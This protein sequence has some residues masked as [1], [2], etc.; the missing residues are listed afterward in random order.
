M[1]CS[2]HIVKCGGTLRHAL[3]PVNTKMAGWREEALGRGPRRERGSVAAALLD[4]GETRAAD[5]PADAARRA[6]VVAHIGPTRTILVGELEDR[7]LAMPKSPSF[8]S[9][10]RETKMFPGETSRC[11]ISSG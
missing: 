11:T 2:P 9:P 10:S 5:A 4:R 7:I 8:T 1:G 3:G 6:E